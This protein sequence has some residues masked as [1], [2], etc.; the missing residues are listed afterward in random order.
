MRVATIVEKP[1][2]G[3]ILRWAIRISVCG[4]LFLGLGFIGAS[5]ALGNPFTTRLAEPHSNVE[6]DFYVLWPGAY[7]ID[8]YAPL[9]EEKDAHDLPC[10]VDVDITRNPDTRHY[11][12]RHAEYPGTGYAQMYVGYE[13]QYIATTDVSHEHL[14]I[15]LSFGRYHISVATH[16][17][18]SLNRRKATVSLTLSGDP[19]G[20]VVLTQLLIILGGLLL[21]PGL[22]VSLTVLLLKLARRLRLP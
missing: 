13:Q 19:T 1:Y 6:G 3:R 15:P 2:L 9:N 5:G 8:F 16:E 20:F 4:G 21:V 7:W 14:Q 17:C 10:F 18:E 11:E 22:V 12:I